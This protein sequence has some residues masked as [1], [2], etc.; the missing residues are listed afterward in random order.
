MPVGLT[1]TVLAL[2]YLLRLLASPQQCYPQCYHAGRNL[3]W[4]GPV[5]ES[6]GQEEDEGEEE[7]RK[8]KRKGRGGKKK[9]MDDD[10]DVI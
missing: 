7:K 1:A 10:N 6:T 8:R 2:L 3:T 9:K 5:G 4:R